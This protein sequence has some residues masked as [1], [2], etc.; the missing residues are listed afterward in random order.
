M[1]VLYLDACIRGEESRT[2]KLCRV[3]LEEIRALYPQAEVTHLELDKLDL[4]PLHRDT[5][6]RRHELEHQG[7]FDDPMFDLGRQLAGADLILVGAPYW[8]ASFPS[9]L[10]VYFEHVSVVNLTF[11]YNEQGAPCGLC[12]GERMLYVTTVGGLMEDKNFGFAFL[13]NLFHLYGVEKTQCLA[14]EGLDIVGADVDGILKEKE[15]DLR[16]LIRDWGN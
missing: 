2:A 8:E 4:R 9:L 10:R 7:S 15:N 3:A 12:R 11:G 6:G 1:N 16:R 13:D 14:A 5:L